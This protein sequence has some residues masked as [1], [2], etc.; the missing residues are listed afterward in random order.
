MPRFSLMLVSIL[1]VA[2]LFIFSPLSSPAQDNVQVE[3]QGVLRTYLSLQRYLADQDAFLKKENDSKISNLLREFTD[4]FH[5]VESLPGKFKLDTLLVS[6]AALT[7]DLIKDATNRFKE[8][9]KTYA[10][11]R[12]RTVSNQCVTCHSRY[13]VPVDFAVSGIDIAALDPFARGEFY[14]ATRQFEKA[15]KAF[16]EI[17]LDKNEKLTRM[18]ALRKWLL[19]MTRVHPDPKEA[20]RDLKRVQEVGGF[21]KSDEIEVGDW[22]NALADWAKERGGKDQPITKA[23][24]L[25]RKGMDKELPLSGTSGVVELLRGTSLLHKLLES[26]DAGSRQRALFLLASAYSSLPPMLAPELP[27]V[28]LEECIRAYPGTKDAEG[29][30]KLYKEIV[31]RDYT[32][33]AGTNIPSDV[34]AEISELQGLAYGVPSAETLGRS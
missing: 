19:V 17:A 34:E 4:S 1:F 15:R 2:A 20:L 26:K 16:L 22:L 25:I 14:F 8:G 32:G 23:E 12:L 21:P 28:L 31:T 18:D 5:K 10:L 9:K 24:S 13:E 11:S 6:N 33:S 3:M 29:A 27:E 30:F 7:E